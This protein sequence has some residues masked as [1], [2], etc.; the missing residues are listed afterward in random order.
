M[1]WRRVLLYTDIIQ[2]IRW[3]AKVTMTSLIREWEGSLLKFR[4]FFMSDIPWRA[5]TTFRHALSQTTF[6]LSPSVSV[7]VSFPCDS[8]A[9]GYLGSVISIDFFIKGRRLNGRNICDMMSRVK[10]FLNEDNILLQFVSYKMF[11]RKKNLTTYLRGYLW[12]NVSRF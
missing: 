4:S 12:V 10:V 8:R 6:L 9:A 7:P 3:I 1:K 11:Q 2:C 5:C